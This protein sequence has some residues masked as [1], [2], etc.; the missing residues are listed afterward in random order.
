MLHEVSENDRSR[1]N[2][3]SEIEDEVSVTIHLDHVFKFGIGN[4]TDGSGKDVNKFQCKTYAT[5]THETEMIVLAQIGTQ[6]KGIER[7]SSPII[8]AGYKQFPVFAQLSSS[9]KQ[10]VVGSYIQ[11]V[12]VIRLYGSDGVLLLTSK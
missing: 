1:P 11:S 6:I 8:A 2:S 5:L 12:Y 3:Y 7:I 4:D 10:T 9:S